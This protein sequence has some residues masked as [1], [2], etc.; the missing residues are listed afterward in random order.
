MDYFREMLDGIQ[1]TCAHTLD[2]MCT[3]YEPIH[4]QT[5]SVPIQEQCQCKVHIR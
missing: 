5:G 1:Y 2:G 3:Y 4:H